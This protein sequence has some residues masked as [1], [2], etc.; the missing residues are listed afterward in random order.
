MMKKPP[1]Q[2]GGFFRTVA[3][4]RGPHFAESATL[5]QSAVI[6]TS[7]LLSYLIAVTTTFPYNHLL[8]FGTLIIW[9]RLFQH[10]DH[11]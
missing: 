9:Q 6:G 11:L 5:E 1:L 3:I 10:V 4:G 8:W 2:S 7:T